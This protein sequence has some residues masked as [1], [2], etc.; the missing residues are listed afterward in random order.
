MEKTTQY[1]NQEKLII[2]LLLLLILCM[3]LILGELLGLESV[4]LCLV[5]SLTGILIDINDGITFRDFGE[6]LVV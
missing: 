5:F 3:F 2:I 4:H 6:G 1:L